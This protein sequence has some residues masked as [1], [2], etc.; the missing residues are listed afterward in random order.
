MLKADVESPGEWIAIISDLIEKEK[1]RAVIFPSNVISNVIAG[2]VYSRERGKVGS[3]LDESDYMEGSVVAKAFEGLS[4]QKSSG[5]KASIVSLKTTSVPEPF[6]DTSRY[7]K[8]RDAANN[9]P[10]SFLME[11]A[12]EEPVSSSLS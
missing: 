10:L 12:P 9:A 1:V 3:F 11:D 5:E 2:A 6:E 7:G 8:V 4:L